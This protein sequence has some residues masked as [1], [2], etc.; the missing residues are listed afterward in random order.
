MVGCVAPDLP[1][2]LLGVSA[3]RWCAGLPWPASLV[4][5]S[6][7][8]SDDTSIGT[9]YFALRL[10]SLLLEVVAGVFWSALSSSFCPSGFS[11]FF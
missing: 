2:G 10:P 6:K 4:P 5:G 9:T 3:S 1:G 8:L 11:A 7:S